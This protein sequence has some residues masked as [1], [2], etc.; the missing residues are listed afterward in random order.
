MKNN[1]IIL[2]AVIFFASC[3]LFQVDPPGTL[4]KS[5]LSRKSAPVYSQEEFSSLV[6][7]NTRFSLDFYRNIQNSDKNL[8][9]SPYSISLALAMTYAGSKNQ[10]ESQISNALCFYKPQNVLHNTFNALDRKIMGNTNTGF[11]LNLVNAAW[12]QDKY[13]FQQTY[14]DVLAL[15]YGAG[16]MSVDFSDN[17]DGIRENINSWVSRQTAN[18][19]PALFPSGSITAST[20]LVLVNAIYFLADWKT[21]FK[22]EDTQNGDFYSF[23]N[24]KT[25]VS[26]MNLSGPFKVTEQS[27]GYQAIELPYKGDKISMLIIMPAD[28]NESQFHE[29]ESNY[30]A[31]DKINA[32]ISNLTNKTI[33]LS[34]PKFKFEWGNSLVN[35]LSAMGMPDAFSGNADFSGID[36]TKDLV[37]SDIIHKAY[38]AVDEKGTEAA[39]A[40]GVVF[41]LTSFLA[42]FMNINRPF[43][44][45]IRD[46][47]SGT[48]LFAGRVVK[49]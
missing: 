2:T 41:K 14:L 40:T 9:Y 1:L 23:G 3:S 28:Q 44:F 29:F 48:I 33:Q 47:D 6:S 13:P 4:V 10:T 45:F 32:I 37:I 42:D 46:L 43:I 16:M 15:N 24:V 35:T 26:M 22:K 36:G 34:M 11:T 12:G 27:N 18:K 25:T 19:I 17:P 21:P 30:L 20:R 38:I 49:P 7:G 31:V 39:A 5:S 8:F